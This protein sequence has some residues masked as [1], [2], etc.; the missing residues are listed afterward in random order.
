M[1]L[2]SS[3]TP[4]DI[5]YYLADKNTVIERRGL[6]RIFTVVEST[7]SIDDFLV[8]YPM[9]GDYKADRI[10]L[11]EVIINYGNISDENFKEK[12]PEKII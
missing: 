9:F 2:L 6:A 12:Y 5:I 3:M 1:S 7:G 4:G 8:I 10:Y 11:D